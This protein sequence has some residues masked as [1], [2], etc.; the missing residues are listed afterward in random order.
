MADPRPL[1]A[2]YNCRYCGEPADSHDRRY[3]HRVGLHTWQGP[4]LQLIRERMLAR[5]AART[6]KDH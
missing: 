4:D 3:H 2:P 5:R 6:R 1:P